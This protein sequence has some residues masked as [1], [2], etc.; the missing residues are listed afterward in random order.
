MGRCGLLGVLVA[1]GCAAALAPA[2]GGG[3]A[4]AVP[5]TAGRAVEV[6]AS[7]ASVRPGET[8]HLH[9]STVPAAGYRIDVARASAATP[10]E[11]D[12]VCVAG[13]DEPQRGSTQPIPL[14]EPATGELHADWPVTDEVVIPSLA[15]SGYYV[16]TARVMDGPA[17]RSQTATTVIVREPRGRP[18]TILIQVPVNTWEA[19]NGWGGRSLYPFT[20]Q[21]GRWGT[22]VTFDRPYDRPDTP[23]VWELQGARFLERQPYTVSYQTDVDTDRHPAT[24]KHHQLVVTLGHGEYWTRAMR[25]G[26]DAARDA[27]TNLVFLGANTGYWQARYEDDRR[28]LVEYRS[29]ADPIADPLDK[30]ILF[31]DLGRAECEL[32]GVQYQGREGSDDY[33]VDAASLGDRWMAGTGFAPDSSVRGVVGPE[34]DSVPA[35][36]PLGCVKPVLTRFFRYGGADGSRAADAVRYVAPS[37]ARVFSSGSLQFAW[38]LDDLRPDDSTG[39]PD[40][41]FQRFMTN[42]LDDLTRPASPLAVAASV[43]DGSTTIDVALQPDLW[44]RS[45]HVARLRTGRRPVV[46]CASL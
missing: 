10:A 2:A 38:G 25:D 40:P 35:V 18:S 22:R 23:F 39:V 4:T 19:Y 28:T 34:R 6:Y 46:V 13:C 12:P 26:F 9:V 30:T 3:R 5:R 1:A 15:P 36:L 29:T 20:S 32:L 41:R 42:A 14:P 21:G 45:V 33:A 37:G 31:R 16:F 7:E 24:L 17:A 27:G 11:R 43:R 44:L 8:V